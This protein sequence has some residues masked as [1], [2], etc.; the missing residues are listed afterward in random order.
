MRKKSLAGKGPGVGQG[1]RGKRRVCGGTCEPAVGWGR[2]RRAQPQLCLQCSRQAVPRDLVRG[3][4]LC[5]WNC[6]LAHRTQLLALRHL[7]S[8]PGRSLLPQ[9]NATWKIR[10]LKKGAAGPSL[11]LPSPLSPGAPTSGPSFPSFQRPAAMGV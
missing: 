6:A 11:V 2:P 4:S 8:S 7:P 9:G 3:Q 5:V 1:G 10:S